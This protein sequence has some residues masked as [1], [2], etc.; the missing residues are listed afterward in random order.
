MH[1]LAEVLFTEM[2]AS[3]E[4]I[5]LTALF[6]LPW[7]LKFLWGPYLDEFGTKRK[8]I[9]ATEFVIV[10]CLLALTMVV[11]FG[12]GGLV[13]ASAI[14]AVLAVF[15]ATHDIAIDGYY[16]EALDEGQQ[17][18]FVGYR[19]P[20]YRVA[21]L[22]VAGPSLIL[23]E[24][25]GW[26]AGFG[27][28]TVIMGGL[29][30]FHFFLLPKADI[31]KQPFSTVGKGLLRPGIMLGLGALVAL[32]MAGRSFLQSE[33]ATEV[34]SSFENSAP[35][36]FTALSKIN[37]AGWI[38]IALLVMLLALLAAMPLLR[39]RMENSDSFYAKAFTSFLAQPHVGRILAFVIL[40]RAG[41][42]FLMKMRYP[43]LK[44]IG[45]SMEQIGWA[46]GTLGMVAAL[47]APAVGGYLISR[48]GLRRWIWPFIIAQN[49]L[50]L[51][52]MGLAAYAETVGPPGVAISTAVIMLEMFGAGLGTAVF[53]V[54]LMRC[55]MPEH[56]GA[57][58]AILT[59]LMSVSFTLAGVA[60]G[61]VA[62]T[63]G[64]TTYFG[65][66]FLLTIPGMLLIFIVPHIDE[67]RA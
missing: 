59:A 66:T 41:E 24:H 63:T 1:T 57:H 65:I 62:S 17:S 32:V 8:W 47:V 27:L 61:F 39:R 43:F 6:H 25:I 30:A 60:S 54:Y 35:E 5:G 26:M 23:I 38:A 46:S 45:L 42:S 50:N 18:K 15:S 28:C 3:L 21:M 4:V 58:M 16:L 22:V 44:S 56:R 13:A 37:A 67:S 48:D 12:P 55:A 31:A 10:A 11:G 53:M 2:K 49:T 20:A 52:Y 33:T 51:L 29:L 19:A 34:S 64:F 14:F 9:V 7:N 40:L 36:L